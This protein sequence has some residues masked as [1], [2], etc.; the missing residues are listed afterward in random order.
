MQP[1]SMNIKSVSLLRIN[2]ESLIVI[3]Q[4]SLNATNISNQKTV[5]INSLFF[6]LSFGINRAAF[7]DTKKRRSLTI[8]NMDLLR[9]FV[10]WKKLHSSSVIER[11]LL[12]FKLSTWIII[13][14]ISS[15]IAVV[16]MFLLVYPLA[17][18]PLFPPCQLVPPKGASCVHHRDFPLVDAVMGCRCVHAIH[19]SHHRVSPDLSA[20]ASPTLAVDPQDTASRKQK[21][22]LQVAWRGSQWVN[23][24][25][26]ML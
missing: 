24:V 23:Y 2:L 11:T 21:S 19:Y 6:I 9:F 3:T 17:A 13:I 4:V 14:I 25:Y 22:N 26:V 1:T 12:F 7:M 20:M 18:T 5:F 15:C 8:I 10:L 16:S